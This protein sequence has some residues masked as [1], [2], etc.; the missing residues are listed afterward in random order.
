MVLNKGRML[1]LAD[2]EAR[3]ILF[4]SPKNSYLRKRTDTTNVIIE[5]A[6]YNTDIDYLAKFNILQ[7]EIAVMYGLGLWAE[8]ESF[9][10][11]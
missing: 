8:L 9:L 7:I 3:D 4:N 2:F 1:L 6:N 5:N 10:D 11:I